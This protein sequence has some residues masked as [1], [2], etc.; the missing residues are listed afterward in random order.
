MFLNIEKPDRKKTAV[1]DDSGYS[2]TYEELCRT[3]E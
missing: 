3:V 2:L 1:K